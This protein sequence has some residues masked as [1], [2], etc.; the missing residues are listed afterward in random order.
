VNVCLVNLPIEKENKN[1]KKHIYTVFAF[2]VFAA[3]ALAN[4]G[5]SLDVKVPFAFKAGD[6]TLPAGTYRVTETTSGV[7]LFRSDKDAVFVPKSILDSGIEDS[8]KASFKFDITGDKYIL[9]EVH[10]EK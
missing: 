7:L 10:P 1:M 5:T 6:S 9:R 2:A 4:S 3:S 8:G